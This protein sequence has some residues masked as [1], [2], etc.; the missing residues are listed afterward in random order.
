M[1]NNVVPSR[2]TTLP[3][4]I[5]SA[6]IGGLCIIA[7]VVPHRRTLFAPPPDDGRPNAT[8]AWGWVAPALEHVGPFHL[9]FNLFWL[10]EL[11]PLLE[12][13]VAKSMLA[14]LAT[15][16]AIL[17]PLITLALYTVVV[18]A[19]NAAQYLST[20]PNFLGLS[21]LIFGLVG[22]LAV[23]F[24]RAMIP[25]TARFFAIWFVVCVGLTSLNVLP[26]ANAAHGVGAATGAFLGWLWRESSS[27]RRPAGSS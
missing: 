4:P 2:P 5:V 19:S 27:L 22:F 24:P 16:A 3:F 18:I 15:P 14:G 12:T 17:P 7:Y 13:S 8:T 11:G 26:V 25:G 9:L 20:G 1:D 6:C 21:G 10:Y 23:A